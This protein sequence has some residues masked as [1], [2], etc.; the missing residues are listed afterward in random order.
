MTKPRDKSNTT[1]YI[2]LISLGLLIAVY[3]LWNNSGFNTSKKDDNQLINTVSC[4]AANKALADN[5]QIYNKDGEFSVQFPSGSNYSKPTVSDTQYTESI[6]PS[7]GFYSSSVFVNR[8]NISETENYFVSIHVLT[9]QP[10]I[11]EIEEYFGSNKLCDRTE[12]SAEA[13]KTSDFFSISSSQGKTYY[14]RSKIFIKGKKLYEVRMNSATP[15]FF[16][17]NDFVNSFKL[18]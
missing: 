3:F 12:N 4:S 11:S 16:G 6:G 14:A 1:T 2:I 9:E 17:Y 10:S 5:Y 15:D 18:Q 13:Y 7:N 8:L